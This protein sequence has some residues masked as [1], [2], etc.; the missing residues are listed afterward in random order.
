MCSIY[1][2]SKLLHNKII[3]STYEELILGSST[4]QVSETEG[5]MKS[6]L[7]C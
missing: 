3:P 2:L 7:N 1:R 5:G 4:G 6:K